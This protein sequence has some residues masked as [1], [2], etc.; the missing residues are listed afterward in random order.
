M[1]TADPLSQ[2]IARIG[3]DLYERQIRPQVETD[4][5]IGRL[6]SIDIHTGDYEVGDNLLETVERLQARRPD[7]EVWTERIGYN[8]VHAVG[9]SLRR[10]DR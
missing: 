4:A 1:P 3:R 5:N 2:E 7:A 6:V 8:A 9:G 10:V